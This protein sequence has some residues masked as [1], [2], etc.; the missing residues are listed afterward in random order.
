MS[1]FTKYF[2]SYK[3]NEDNTLLINTLTNAIDVVDNKLMHFINKVIKNEEE[4]SKINKEEYD[5]LK[6]RGYIF[7]SQDDEKKLLKK[8]Q[9]IRKKVLKNTTNINYWTICPSMECNLNC[10]YCYEDNDQ[11][12]S[13]KVLSEKHLDVIFDFILHKKMGNPRIM[14]FGGEPLLKTNYKIIEKILKF[15]QMNNFQIVITTNGTTLNDEYLNLL[16]DYK[17]NLQVQITLDGNK[18]EHNKKRIFKNGQGTFDIIC[19]NVNYLLKMKVPVSIRI[20]IDKN[21]IK[22]L[23]NLKN[24]FTK[25]RW[26]QNDNFVAY[27]APVRIYTKNE[28]AIDDS[29]MLDIIMKNKWYDHTFIKRLDSSVFDSL[30][31]FFNSS[32]KSSTVKLW[33]MSYCAATEGT[34]YCF[35]PNGIITTCLRGIGRKEYM[36]GEFDEKS[37]SIDKNKLDMWKNRS[38]FEMKKCKDCKFILLCGGGCAK[39][40]IMKHEDIN[41]GVCNDIEKTLEV[42]VKYNKDKFIIKDKG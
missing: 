5:K 30:F 13:H 33:Q 41:C 6:Q 16:S 25:Q 9:K 19:N 15:G 20:N 36:I 8:Y 37:V 1:Y 31:S 18:E 4:I 3:L 38:P 17:E 28:I 29:E 39:S 7:D 14:I 27:V 40:S 12:K 34:H 21:N 2:C 22:N 35:A 24:L 10:P 11:H 23:E 42:Y 32:R 26:N